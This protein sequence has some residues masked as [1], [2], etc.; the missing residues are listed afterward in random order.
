MLYSELKIEILLFFK[1]GP[2][3]L[4]FFPLYAIEICYTRSSFSVYM[5]TY[6]SKSSTLTNV[7]NGST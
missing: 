1:E 5:Y 3:P 7:C 4:I 2:T 6:A